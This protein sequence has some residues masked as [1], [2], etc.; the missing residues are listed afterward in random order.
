MSKKS[1][2][3]IAYIVIFIFVFI[4][5]QALFHY[6]DKEDRKI[7]YEYL[8]QDNE[9]CYQ[10]AER[11]KIEKS[12]CYEIRKASLTNYG[13]TENSQNTR[14]LLLLFQPILFVLLI[15]IRNLRK[16]VD[17]LKEKIND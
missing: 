7:F 9:I 11:D 3:I 10:R 8:D 17:E 16:E 14:I 12:W 5:P 6:F 4:V 13:M 15:S 1:K 2:D